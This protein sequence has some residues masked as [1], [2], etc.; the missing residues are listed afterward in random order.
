MPKPTQKSEEE[1]ARTKRLVERMP[2]D[3]VV[4]LSDAIE[5]A[6]ANGDLDCSQLWASLRAVWKLHSDE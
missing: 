5:D 2:D 6:K 4:A 1:Y 3:L